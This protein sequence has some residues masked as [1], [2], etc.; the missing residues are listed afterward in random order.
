[1][2]VRVDLGLQDKQQSWVTDAEVASKCKRGK[3]GH[4]DIGQNSRMPKTLRSE[5]GKQGRKGRKEAI[6]FLGFLEHK[7]LEHTKTT[8]AEISSR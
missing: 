1:L 7:T 8:R 5:T 6:T 3:T 2:R 4:G